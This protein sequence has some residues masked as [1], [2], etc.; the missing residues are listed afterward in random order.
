MSGKKKLERIVHPRCK[1]ALS[2]LG[3]RESASTSLDAI[4]IEVTQAHR[5]DYVVVIKTTEGLQ[6]KRL[7]SAVRA[8]RGHT[9]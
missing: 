6:L 4:V 5:Y 3:K 8:V 7:N 9:R 1:Q 2:G